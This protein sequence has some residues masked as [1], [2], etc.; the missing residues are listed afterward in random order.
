MRQ[1]IIA[2][3]Q[4]ITRAGLISILK[5]MDDH[6]FIVEASNYNNLQSSLRDEPR[7]LVVV[8]YSL[9]DFL[10]INHFLNMK[11]G[12]KESS[13]LL[14]SHELEEHFLR[15]TLLADPSFSVV[16]KQSKGGQIKEALA[17]ASAGE[18]YWCDLAE[19]VMK[20][21]VARERMPDQLTVSEKNILREIALGKTTKEIAYERNL[22]FHTVNTHR[23]NIY[24]KLEVNSVNEATRF[25][26]QAGLIDL[27]EYY[28]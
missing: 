3:N 14:F 23:R 4:Y 10:S 9:F 11:S 16:L 1:Y 18:V 12:A 21:P 26:L 15:Q 2:D 8:D 24:Q 6:A 27:M 5:E 22:S 13:W 19:S 20:M 7:S 17:Q 25:A 28:I